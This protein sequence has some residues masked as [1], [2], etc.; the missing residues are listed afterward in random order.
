MRVRIIEQISLCKY[1]GHFIRKVEDEFH[2]VLVFIDKPGG[3]YENAPLYM[4]DEDYHYSS[5]E[6]AKRAIRGEQTKWISIDGT[7][8]KRFMKL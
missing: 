5:V 3:E 2:N 4:K 7:K 8:D 1:K 6:D